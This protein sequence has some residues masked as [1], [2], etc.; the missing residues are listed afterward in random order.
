[1]QIDILTL[2][3]E[4]FNGIFDY[5]IIKRAQ[6]KGELRINIY[7]LREWATDN[8]KSVD[9]RP[10]GGGAGMIMR[11][12]IIDR[13]L[14]E[15]KNKSNTKGKKAVKVVLTD[16][17]GDQ[18]TQKKA[19]ALAKEEQVIFIAGHYEGIDAR[20][21]EHLVDEALSIGPY[22]LSGGELPIAVMVDSITR[23]VPG[24]LGN[25]ESLTEESHGEM[26]REYPQ[27][28]R[29]EEYK[30]WKVPEILLSGDHKKIQEWRKRR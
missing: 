13:A 9:D 11:V 19:E 16:A 14:E 6:E 20:V 28:T 24:V 3:P 10:Y 4:T 30:G 18:F 1:M 29:P 17:A 23:L 5:S 12:D 7:N 8:Y 15:L 26:K 2:F 22:V 25:P 21:K 27:Y